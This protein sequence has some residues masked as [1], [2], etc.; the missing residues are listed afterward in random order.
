MFI[1]HYGP[2]FAATPYARGAP[3]LSFF[4]AVQLLDV[5]WGG[6]LALGVEHVRYAPGFT[7]ANPYEL[8]DIPYTH[9][10]PAAVLWALG[11]GLAWRYLVKVGGTRAAALIG[12]AVFSHWILDLIVHVPDLLLWPGG[13]KVGLGLWNNAPLSYTVETLTVLGGFAV[14]M[15]G[16]RPK[17]PLGRITPWALLAVLAAI[18]ATVALAPPG[19]SSPVAMG[20]SVLAVYAVMA[21]AAGAVDLTRT[22]KTA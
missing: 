18:G 14:Y 4:V 2:A 6:L 8:T 17:G 10:L 19:D 15:R 5:G 13:P 9:S 3:L 16:T 1:G 20:L 21:L 12:L 7:A 11:A 22:L